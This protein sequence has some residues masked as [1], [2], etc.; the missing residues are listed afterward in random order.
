MSVNIHDEA[1]LK[2]EDDLDESDGAKKPIPIKTQAH[3]AVGSR[4]RKVRLEEYEE[5]HE[6]SPPFRRFTFRLLEFLK[7]ALDSEL[8]LRSP[9]EVSF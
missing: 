3:W 4:Q 7:G 6:G 9:I 8:Q 2:L 5:S 1:I